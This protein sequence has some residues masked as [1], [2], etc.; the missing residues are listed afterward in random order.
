MKTTTHDAGEAAA[1]MTQKS[2][3]PVIGAPAPGEMGAAVAAA[4][5]RAG[6]TALTVLAGRSAESRER[7]AE[8][9]MTA[10]ADLDELVAGCDLFLSIA[11]PAAALPLAEAAA[12]SMRRTGARP[13]FVE[14]NAISPDHLVGI[15]ALFDAEAFVDGGIIGMPPHGGRR[16]RLYISG[17]P[18]PALAH[19]DGVAFE[20]RPLGVRPGAA[21]A[22]KMC[23]GGVTKGVNAILMAAL[24]TAEGF[25]LAEP[26][27]A[28][29]SASQ[30]GLSRRLETGG[31]RLHADAGRWAPEMREISQSFA[32]RGLPGELH[33]GAARL[34]EIL[35]RSSLGAET[36]RTLDPARSALETAR[37]ILADLRAE[38]EDG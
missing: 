38:R 22:I 2:G 3:L 34:Y 10:C 15:G 19:L 33:E 11:P 31:P 6:G 24:L 37:I 25:D 14:C 4:Y 9:G 17:P 18:C 29:L 26:F 16:P 35:D 8:A 1:S 12:A 20:I 21:S 7:A 30:S 27:M 36:R 23:Y 32:S 28:E 5:V 13:P